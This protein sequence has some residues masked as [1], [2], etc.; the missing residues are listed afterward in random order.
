MEG[1]VLEKMVRITSDFGRDYTTNLWTEGAFRFM[2]I[3]K[4]GKK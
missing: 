3:V 4:Q 1:E 2:L